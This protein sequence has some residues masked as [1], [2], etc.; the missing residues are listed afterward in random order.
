MH[1]FSFALSLSIGRHSFLSK[2]LLHAEADAGTVAAAFAG[3]ILFRGLCQVVAVLPAES[4]ADFVVL[5]E[6][7]LTAAC[8]PLLMV[9]DT[10]DQECFV[11]I[12]GDPPYP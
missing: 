5:P 4:A 9:T 7:A 3:I 1:R 11:V 12:H 10:V 8:G 2:D 6:V